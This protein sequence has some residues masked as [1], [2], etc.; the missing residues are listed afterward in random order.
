MS[1][2]LKEKQFLLFLLNTQAKQAQIIL[3]NL[4]LPQISCLKEICY[5]LVNNT[6]PLTD[7]EIRRLTPYKKIIKSISN[8]SVSQKKKTIKKNK[9]KVYKILKIIDHRIYDIVSD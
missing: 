4:T 7:K 9:E 3:A 2:F 1:H 6:F 8:S 5:N